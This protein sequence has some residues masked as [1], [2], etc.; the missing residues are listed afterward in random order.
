MLLTT[1][2]RVINGKFVKE[3]KLDLQ[4]PLMF[5]LI[6]KKLE[7]IC[8]DIANG[9]NECACAND[10]HDDLAKKVKSAMKTCSARLRKI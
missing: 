9:I 8:S 5:A 10:I 2:S 6:E 3:D 4:P 7:S 1:L